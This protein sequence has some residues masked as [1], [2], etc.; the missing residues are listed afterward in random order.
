MKKYAAFLL[1]VITVITLLAGCGGNSSSPAAKKG[2]LP[3]AKSPFDTDY[4]SENNAPIIGHVTTKAYADDS[5]EVAGKGFL[6]D[7]L[8]V[9]L[10]T[11]NGNK[12]VKYNV[13]DDNLMAVLIPEDVKKGVFAL[14]AENGSG[15]SNLKLINAPKIWNLS[16]DTVTKNEELYIYGENLTLNDSPKVFLSDEE[17]Y[18]EPHITYNDPHKV[19]FKVP[20]TLKN[21]K[22]YTVYVY[23]GSAGE[24][25]LAVAEQK[26]TYKSEITEQFSGKTVDVTDYGAD[27]KDIKN[28]DTAAVKKAAE[29]LKDGDTLYFPKGYYLINGDIEISCSVKIRGDSA[30][31]SVILGGNGVSEYVFKITSLPSEIR[32]IR[33]EMKRTSGK[34]KSGFVRIKGDSIATGRTRVNI[35]GCKFVQ[36]VTTDYPSH[37]YPLYIE[38][39]NGLVIENNYSDS[40]GFLTLFNVQNSRISN[41]IVNSGLFAGYYYGQD[42]VRITNSKNLDISGNTI[43]GKDAERDMRLDLNSYTA[44]RAVVIQGYG[45]NTYFGLNTLKKA[46]LPHCN[47]GE[48]FLLENLSAE[49]DGGAVSSSDG[50]VSI[51]ESKKAQIK[52]DSV[53]SVVSGDGKYQYRTV[54]SAK[55]GKLN[56]DEDFDAPLSKNSRVFITRCFLNT[57]IYSNV[58][59][60][61]SNWDTDPGSGTSL[62]AYGSTHNLYME[63]NTIKDLPEGICLTPYFYN[64]LTNN[65]KAVLAWSVFDNN[66]FENNGVGIRYS[67]A[68]GPG[69]GEALVTVSNG[70][71]IRRN[72]FKSTPDYKKEGW[73][74]TGGFAISIGALPRMD[75]GSSRHD[76]WDGNWINGVL[77]ENCGFK[78]SGQADIAFCTGQKNTLI[79]KNNKGLKTVIYDGASGA[80]ELKY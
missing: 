76:V 73:I 53:V 65:C 66:T 79:R 61:Y 4:K 60:G 62:Q 8:K 22:K 21:G 9:Y 3:I 43:Q 17:E 36:S 67:S 50:S 70:I 25:G 38:Q 59:D 12:S 56:L 47:A 74:Y 34:I 40:T 78:N 29:V 24:A 75:G 72:N 77:I 57:A 31:R 54:K 23:N 6:G 48:L 18:F 58:F 41:N 39:V 80:S 71:L 42:T 46:G 10:K 20:E 68:G 13:I 14:Y 69:I 26:L 45:I 35:S 2:G 7:S 49:Y 11:E 30:D 64:P 37:A 27:A 15:K 28:D 32:D 33:F 5:A 52:A 19:A 16:S 1:S 55:G 44:G 51:D 63:E